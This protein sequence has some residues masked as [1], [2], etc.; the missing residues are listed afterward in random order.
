MVANYVDLLFL[1]DPSQGHWSDQ[2]LFCCSPELCGD[3]P[4]SYDCI[5]DVLSTSSWFSVRI[6]PHVD[7]FVGESE[8]HIVL[9]RHLNP[10]PP[11][12]MFF[13]QL[14]SQIYTYWYTSKNVL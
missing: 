11:Q 7:V 14:F 9:L 12:L 10:P 6:V 3:L 5:E 1:T 4:C 8:L 13:T 2:L